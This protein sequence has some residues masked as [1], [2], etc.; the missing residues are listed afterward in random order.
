[1]KRSRPRLGGHSWSDRPLPEQEEHRENTKNEEEEKALAK[2]SL[3]LSVC[4]LAPAET[5]ARALPTPDGICARDAR[6]QKKPP[7]ALCAACSLAASGWPLG[8][9]REAGTKKRS[10]G[11]MAV[12]LPLPGH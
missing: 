5:A 6:V 3:S 2:S 9:V 4:S 11:V 12:R 1:M 8:C 10:S 7:R